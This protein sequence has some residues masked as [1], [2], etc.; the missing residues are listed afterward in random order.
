MQAH[1]LGEECADRTFS[2]GPCYEHG[3]EFLVRIVKGS[4]DLPYIIQPE[5]DTQVLDLF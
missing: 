3:W 5:F 2:V 4:K 1:D